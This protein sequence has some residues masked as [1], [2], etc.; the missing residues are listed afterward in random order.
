MP[1]DFNTGE[2][3]TKLRRALNLKGSLPLTLDETGVG[4][5]QIADLDVSPYRLTGRSLRCWGN[6]V[7]TVGQFA[8]ISFRNQGQR[9][10]VI[11]QAYVNVGGA[12]TLTWGFATPAGAPTTAAAITG[13]LATSGTIDSPVPPVAGV[14]RSQSLI[15]NQWDTVASLGASVIQP[16]FSLVFA[17]GGSL[18]LDN[19]DITLQ[20]WT[21]TNGIEYLFYSSTVTF[22]LGV[23]IRVRS[24]D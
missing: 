21:V 2:S 15:A 3:A 16:D 11:E 5:Y 14:E 20:P 10:L 4:V 1:V 17:G 7:P 18:F 24:Y 23:G 19:L 8:A 13:E 22:G 9:P 12:L 6:K